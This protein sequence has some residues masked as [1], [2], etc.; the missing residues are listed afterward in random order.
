VIQTQESVVRN[1]KELEEIL[2]MIGTQK[3]KIEVG[4][5]H[6]KKYI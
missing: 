4:K 1:V 5:P 3:D 6:G 2:D